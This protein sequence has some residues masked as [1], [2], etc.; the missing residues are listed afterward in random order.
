MITR[1]LQEESNKTHDIYSFVLNNMEVDLGDM[2]HSGLFVEPVFFLSAGTGSMFHII[3]SN[4]LKEGQTGRRRRLDYNFYGSVVLLPFEASSL[5]RHTAR[6]I[7]D[8]L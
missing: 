3:C 2:K 5:L 8:D 1:P 4:V 6:E 7:P